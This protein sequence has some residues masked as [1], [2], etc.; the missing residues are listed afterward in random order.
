MRRRL[1]LSGLVLVGITSVA[2]AANHQVKTVGRW[3]CGVLTET[4][5]GKTIAG[6][7]GRFIVLRSELE[8]TD[9]QRDQIREVLVSHRPEIAETV[10]SVREKR[11]VLREAIRADD[12]QEATIRTAA[13]DLGRAISDAAVKAAKLRG[14][15]A[16]LLTAD[17]HEL[18]DKFFAENDTAID[19]FLTA[20]AQGK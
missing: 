18:I 11:I 2:M 5:L 19:A 14:E 6:C 10:K 20:A 9:E 12:A 8:V 13:D 4:P 17:Q 1:I 3:G 15:I 16:P 7:V